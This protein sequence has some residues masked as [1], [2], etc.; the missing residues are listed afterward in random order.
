MTQPR[1]NFRFYGVEQDS[2]LLVEG[3]GDARFFR[4]FLRNLNMTGVQIAAVGDVN[5]FAPFLTNTLVRDPGISRLRKLALVRDADLDPEAAFRSLQMALIRASLPS[6][7]G[8]YEPTS[9]GQPAVS[10]AILPDG[11]SR[12]NLEDLCLRSI[13]GS[14]GND[15]A[16]RCVAQYLTCRGVAPKLRIRAD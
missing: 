15:A 11:N 4:A 1:Q 10:I 9:T 3:I 2:L 8:I 12:G 16:M 6:P 14:G 7:A 13:Q 5:Q